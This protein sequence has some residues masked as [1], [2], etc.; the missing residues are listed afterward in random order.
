M[1]K[2]Q[3][4]GHGMALVCVVV[5]GSTF[6]VSKGLMT[7]LQPV[8]LMLLRFILAYLLLWVLHPKWYFRWR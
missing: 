3:W 1:K 4:M 8:Q 7:F 5:W 2:S 6:M